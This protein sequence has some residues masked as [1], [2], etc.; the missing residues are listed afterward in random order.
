[1]SATI[2][3]IPPMTQT[4]PNNKK[5]QCI[6]KL[7]AYSAKAAIPNDN[8]KRETN[9]I[10]RYCE[11]FIFKTSKVTLCKMPGVAIPSPYLARSSSFAS[12]SGR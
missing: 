5:N 3:L 7:E 4:I 2:P 8:M 11:K 12:C 9:V 10:K 6:V 1:M